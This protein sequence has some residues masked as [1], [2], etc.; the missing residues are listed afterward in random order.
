MCI[1]NLMRIDS[2]KAQWALANNKPNDSNPTLPDILIFLYGR[3]SISYD[4]PPICP[5]GGTYT[6]HRVRDP[7]TCSIPGHEFNDSLQNDPVLE[8]DAREYISRERLPVRR[9]LK[10]LIF[11]E[12]PATPAKKN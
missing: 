9:F 10:A 11:N 3:D 12:S 6:L 8:S 2:A 1:S 5:S 4:S 7:A